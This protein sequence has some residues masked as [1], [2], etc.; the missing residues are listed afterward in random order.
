MEC[1]TRAGKLKKQYNDEET[2]QKTAELMG[3]R[4]K[5]PFNHYQCKACGFWHV[6]RENGRIRMNEQDKELQAQYRQGVENPRYTGIR[7]KKELKDKVLM[8]NTK[9]VVN[10]AKG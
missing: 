6:G 5:E 10:K 1:I 8:E 7:T 4:Y 3:K 2:A 9:R